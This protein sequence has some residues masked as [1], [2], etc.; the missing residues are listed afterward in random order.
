MWYILSGFCIAYVTIVFHIISG[1]RVY[2]SENLFSPA[3]IFDK[4]A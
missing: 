2:Y 4:T 3:A 1:L